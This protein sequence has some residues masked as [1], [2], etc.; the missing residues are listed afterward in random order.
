MPFEI[1]IVES[2][3][4]FTEKHK[5]SST[6]DILY[7][8]RDYAV[9]TP[10]TFPLDEPITRMIEDIEQGEIGEADIPLNSIISAIEHFQRTGNIEQFI[11]IILGYMESYGRRIREER[12]Y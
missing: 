1:E 2:K 6:L 8:L 11:L 12:L 9:K 5:Y 10:R 3:K 7:A 4:T